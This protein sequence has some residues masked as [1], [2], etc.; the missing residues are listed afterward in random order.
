MRIESE[1]INQLVYLI[2]HKS[3]HKNFTSTKA[4]KTADFFFKTYNMS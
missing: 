1:N 2:Y 4:Q 3:Q